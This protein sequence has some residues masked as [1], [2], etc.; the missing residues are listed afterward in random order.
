MRTA[1][2]RRPRTSVWTGWMARPGRLTGFSSPLL[3]CLGLL[4][5]GFVLQGAGCPTQQRGCTD[6]YFTAT[7]DGGGVVVPDCINSGTLQFQDSEVVTFPGLTPELR[8]AEVPASGGVF[9]L[10]FTPTAMAKSGTVVVDLHDV[11]DPNFPRITQ[12][13]TLHVTLVGPA[14]QLASLVIA[15]SSASLLARQTL[16]LHAIGTFS[17]G[18]TADL[19]TQVQWSSDNTAVATVDSG[20]LAGVVQAVTPG[21]AHVTATALGKSTSATITVDAQNGATLSSIAITPNPASVVLGSTLPFTATGTYSDGS[22]RDIT[23]LV[24]WSSSNSAV[25]TIS[26][27]VPNQGVALGRSAGTATLT[28]AASGLESRVTLTVQQP[29]ASLISLSIGPAVLSVPIGGTL[30]LIATG[31]YDDGSLRDITAA[32][33]WSSMDST[34]AG[35][36]NAPLSKGLATGVQGGV[37]TVTATDPSGVTASRALTVVGLQAI[38]V[39]PNPATVAAGRQV[40]FT[41]TGTYSDGTAR[42]VSQSVQWTSQL[43]AVATINSNGVA[44]GVSPGV[45]T[46]LATDPATQIQGAAP[47]TVTA[48][49]PVSLSIAPDPASV[50]VGQTLALTASTVNTDGSVTDVTGQVTWSSSNPPAATIGAGGA[51]AGVATGVA[52]GSTTIT[53]QLGSGANVL[54]A[55]VTLTVSVG[56]V[57]PIDVTALPV[58]GGGSNLACIPQG[59]I[60]SP[61]WSWHAYRDD[62]TTGGLVFNNP[63]VEAPVAQTSPNAAGAGTG[64]YVFCTLTGANGAFGS[65]YVLIV[66]STGETIENV[67]VTPAAAHVNADVSFD[68]TSSSNLQGPLMW[69]VQYAGNVVPSGIEGYLTIP[70][71]NWTTV[72]TTVTDSSFVLDVP[73]GFANPGAYR[74]QLTGSST[75]D[76]SPTMQTFYFQVLQ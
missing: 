53:A 49:T 15:P 75:L 24:T 47:L 65:G 76:F 40:S 30:Q 18:T 20:L 55:H 72:L 44:T 11:P 29:A 64:F 2:V 14:A 66:Y 42:D 54:V 12:A 74:L 33:N 10:Q 71:G 35:V 32:V 38:A 5:C 31:A 36:S 57:V 17:D 4:A 7:I 39:T 1:R 70:Q 28:A 43:Q 45:A 41:A 9:E 37:V 26:N 22:T 27:L 63:A 16:P 50:L 58:V 68:A 48:A 46:I 21:S 51:N 56:T 8:A 19:T 34:I 25:A 67:V 69:T 52:P 13:Y 6:I 73:A 3:R 62:G 61:V 60:S 59:A 23:T